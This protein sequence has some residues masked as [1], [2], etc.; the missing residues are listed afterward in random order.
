MEEGI[1]E[2]RSRSV[3]SLQNFPA[4]GDLRKP[5]ED[6]VEQTVRNNAIFNTR[7]SLL[8][9]DDP[10]AILFW[11]KTLSLHAKKLK[12]FYLRV[13]KGENDLANSKNNENTNNNN[14]ENNNNDN[15]NDNNNQH[16]NIN[17]INVNSN[18]INENQENNEDSELFHWSNNQIELVY[19][20]FHAT[21]I[22]KFELC[23]NL[24]PLNSFENNWDPTA[25]LPLTSGKGKKNRSK[26]PYMELCYEWGLA[27]LRYGKALEM[28]VRFFLILILLFFNFCFYFFYFLNLF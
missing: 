10:K 8:N 24:D 4:D 25:Y 23:S 28:Q 11:A 22:Q 1:T 7:E 27:S 20:H 15:N 13:K 14:E 9:E 16:E 2:N 3:I 18:I 12:S 6:L 26:F 5:L 17:E 21:S 19:I